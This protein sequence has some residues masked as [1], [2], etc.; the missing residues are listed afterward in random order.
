M[1]RGIQ[2]THGMDHKLFKKFE[3][4]LSGHYHVASQK[5]N[6]KYLGSQMEFFWNGAGDKKYFHVLDNS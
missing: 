6:I 2:N 5:D 4:V 1:M 3:M